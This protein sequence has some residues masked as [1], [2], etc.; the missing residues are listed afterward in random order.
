MT[1]MKCLVL[2]GAGFI[3]SH[4]VDALVSAGNSVTVFDRPNISL[5]NLKNSIDDISII[6]GDLCNP[7]DVEEVI[8]GI[9]LIYHFAA[10][11]L[12]GPSNLNPLYDVETNIVATIGLMENAVKANVKKI[13]FASS[14]GTIY[15]I[16][17]SLP[18]TEHH[19]TDPVCSY[20]ITKLAIE[21]YL[22]LFNHLHNLHYVILRF[23]NPYGERQRTNSVQG[24]IPVFLGKIKNN[25]IIDIW[26]DGTV[27]RDYFYISD[28]VNAVLKAGNSTITHDVF[29]IAGGT[30]YSLLDILSLIEKVTGI[31]PQVRFLPRREFDVPVNYLDIRKAKNILNWQPT[32]SL[33]EGI[34]RTWGWIRTHL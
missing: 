11:T 2:G 23:G 4:V 13:I 7:T 32:V 8:Q 26:G 9:D 34:A 22:A 28:L 30:G 3:G 21:K 33:E 27:A 19:A 29:N 20:G 6:Q 5:E 17:Q 14:G 10:T 16:P 12:P 31:K 15:G 24:V 25:D 1:R 18:I